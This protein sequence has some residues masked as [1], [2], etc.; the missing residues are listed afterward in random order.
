MSA[1]AVAIVVV[2]IYFIQVEL[3]YNVVLISAVQQ[4]DSVIHTYPSLSCFV[5]VVFSG[6]VGV[7]N[8]GNRNQ[9]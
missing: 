6:R 4:S 3:I 5:L 2:L 8:M 1:A 9:S 7:N